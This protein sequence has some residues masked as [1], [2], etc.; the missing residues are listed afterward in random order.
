[1]K[2]VAFIFPGQGSQKKGM[3][4]DFYN[5]SELAKSIIDSVSERSGIDF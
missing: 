4:E 3:G 5:N 2:K 1:M